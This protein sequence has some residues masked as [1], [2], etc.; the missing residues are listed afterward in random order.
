VS[1]RWTKEQLEF[2]YKQTYA[3]AV[4]PALRR[5]SAS[6]DSL[7]E[8]SGILRINAKVPPQAVTV[9]LAEPNDM[10]R[11]D[12]PCHPEEPVKVDEHWNLDVACLVC[13]RCDGLLSQRRRA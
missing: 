2:I 4:A 1:A 13:G 6:I 7:N 3:A 8:S 10:I 12:F 5:L 9:P 11:V